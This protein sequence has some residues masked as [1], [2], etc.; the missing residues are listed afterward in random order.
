MSMSRLEATITRLTE[1]TNTLLP[2]HM[3]D[4]AL[5]YI[6]D[7]IP[8]G[9]FMRAVFAND[10]V[11]AAGRADAKNRAALFQWVQFLFVAPRGCWGSEAAVDAWCAQGGLRGLIAKAAV[12]EEPTSDS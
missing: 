8:P 4:G 6:L 11:E 7:G 2:E 5:R 12:P 3:R 9:D 1:E 10:L